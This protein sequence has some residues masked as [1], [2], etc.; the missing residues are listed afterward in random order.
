MHAVFVV[1][2]AAILFVVLSPGIIFSFPSRGTLLKRVMVHSVIFASLLYLVYIVSCGNNRREEG[3]TAN[4][5]K[6][7]SN[8]S[9]GSFDT[10]LNL[11]GTMLPISI[12]TNPDGSV[13]ITSDENMIIDIINNP[14]NYFVASTPS[15]ALSSL[16]D[17]S[18]TN[19]QLLPTKTSFF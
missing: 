7:I 13:S 12:S 3:F 15:I 2:L 1:V 10:S 18:G 6:I 5:S 11:N 17:V 19:A 4:M 14:A 16:S 9:G 8:A